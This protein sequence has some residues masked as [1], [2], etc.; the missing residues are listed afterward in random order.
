MDDTINVKRITIAGEKYL[1]DG[2]D[3]LY[4]LKTQEHIGEYDRDNDEITFF[5]EEEEEYPDTIKV[6]DKKK[7][8]FN[9]VNVKRITLG[10]EDYLIDKYKTLYD[11]NTL[12]N[13]KYE[14]R[15]KTPIGDYFGYLNIYK[16]EEELPNFVVKLPYPP[17]I[18]FN[19][20]EQAYYNKNK[21]KVDVNVKDE[22]ASNKLYR[23]EKY[24]S[25]ISVYAKEIMGV[26]V[27]KRVAQIEWDTGISKERPYTY[28]EGFV[29]EKIKQIKEKYANEPDENKKATLKR[30]LVGL[31]PKIQQAKDVDKV[32]AVTIPREMKGMAEEESQTKQYLRE[33]GW[34]EEK[35]DRRL[36]AIEDAKVL[37]T[38][39]EVKSLLT[40]KN[41]MVTIVKSPF[42]AVRFFTKEDTDPYGYKLSNIKDF[43]YFLPDKIY[44]VYTPGG[45]KE[46]IDPDTL[47]VLGE[48][49]PTKN[50]LSNVPFVLG[51]NTLGKQR[52]AE[53]KALEKTGGG[54]NEYTNSK[55]AKKNAVKYLGKNVVLKPSTKK[56]KKFM[57]LNPDTNKFIHF[58]Q[59]GF[60]DFT[61]H[62]DT[63]R[64]TSYLNRTA[65]MRGDWK[66]DKYSANNLARE[67]LW[68]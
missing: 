32:E 37:L 11:D 46:L 39:E 31:I 63:K 18:R 57:V 27:Y 35:E 65:N 58:G 59:L 42:T 68:R 19:E 9:I 26:V 29:L 54:L 56:D 8:V 55:I 61:K 12:Y 60:E 67:I 48:F 38:P 51:L 13:L 53:Y 6:F 43:E 21:Q 24:R 44:K 15:Y 17:N 10:G 50:I 64:Q 2:D 4:D 52:L 7:Q 33:K 20:K 66:D 45:S 49:E 16:K 41:D 28:N 1:I 5:E 34:A 14:P 23:E 25:T 3:N 22:L 36:K 47:Q 62:Q 30:T 40:K